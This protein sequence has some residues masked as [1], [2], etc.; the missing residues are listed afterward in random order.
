MQL[1]LIVVASPL[2]E[3]EHGLALGLSLLLLIGEFLLVNLD[4]IFTGQI[5]QS[6][7]ITELLMLHDEIDSTAALATSKALANALSA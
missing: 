4:V 1:F 2:V 5:T 6:L 7:G 3:H